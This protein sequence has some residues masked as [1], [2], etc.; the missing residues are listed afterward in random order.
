VKTLEVKIWMLRKGIRQA[1]V[2]AELGVSRPLVSM[3][4]QGTAR[5]RR[6]LDWLKDHGCPEEYLE[7]PRGKRP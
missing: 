7:Y 2:A 6:V 4:I 5:N 1:E 3:T